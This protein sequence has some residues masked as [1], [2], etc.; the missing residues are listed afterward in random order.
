MNKIQRDDIASDLK[1]AIM[2]KKKNM[3]KKAL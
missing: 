1:K 2:A 3:G